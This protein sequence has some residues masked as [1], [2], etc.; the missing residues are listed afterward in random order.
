MN[1]IHASGGNFDEED[2]SDCSY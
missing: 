1:S 2:W